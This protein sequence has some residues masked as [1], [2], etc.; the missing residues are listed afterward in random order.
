M[1][2]IA[3]PR[4]A[5]AVS[6]AGA[7]GM[8]SVTGISDEPERVKLWIEETRGLTKNPFGANF[9][10]ADTFIPDLSVIK[11]SVEIASKTARVVEFFYRQPDPSLVELVHKRGALAFWQVGSKE[12]AIA[13]A[14]ARCDVIVAQGVEAGGHLRG[15]VG[16][17]TLLSEVLDSVKVPVLAAG[18][19]G[20]G[21]AMAAALAA[22]ASGVR[23]GTRFVAAEESGAHPQYIRALISSG[24]E[25]TVV[26]EAFSHGWPNAPHRVLRSSLEAAQSFKGDIVGKR[27]PYSTGIWVDVHRFQ[28]VGVTKEATGHIEAMPHWAGES[29]EGVTRV[30]SAADIVRDL[31]SEAESALRSLSS[32]VL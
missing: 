15:K 5:A 13:A 4:L 23:V 24:A 3:N 7:L 16:L 19:I 21:R 11:E 9:I 31:S 25:D 10:V 1:G 26:T 12:E 30:Q 14:S 22:G 20:T 28:P 32:W 27:N 6:N 8:V 2:D 29:V 18:G 17:L